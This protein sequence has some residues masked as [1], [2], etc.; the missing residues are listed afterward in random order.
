MSPFA[1][2]STPSAP[3]ADATADSAVAADLMR[4]LVV[5]DDPDTR[6]NLCDIL[7]LDGYGTETASTIAE[8]RSRKDVAAFD[9]IILDRKLPDGTA[10][11]LL[12]WL[13]QKGPDASVIVVTGFADLDGAIAALRAGAADYTLKP[14][15]ADALRARL[16]AIDEKRRLS[17]EKTRAESAFRTLIE[18]APCLIV[19]SRGPGEVVFVNSCAAGVTGYTQQ[20]LAE[21]LPPRCFL[22]GGGSPSENT[23]KRFESP[24]LCRDGVRHW[25]I[26]QTQELLDY[27]G[28]AALM[29][30]GQDITELQTAQQKAL[31][32]ERLAAIGQMMAGLSHESRNALQRSKACLEMLEFE[33][34]DRPEA[35]ELVQRLTKAQDHLQRLYEEVR[36]YAAPVQISREQ[37]N[38]VNVWREKWSHIAPLH[39]NKH[40]TLREQ[41]ETDH[42]FC[43]GDYFALGQV[44]GNILENAITVVPEPGEIVVACRE[45]KLGNEEALEVAFIDNGPGLD[46]EQAT[47]IF[48]PFFTTKTKGTGLGMAIAKRII[49]AHG[50]QISVRDRTAPGAEVVVVLP[51]GGD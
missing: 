4:V 12:P 18:A 38:V 22:V 39:P 35:M 11:E 29:A 13:K 19:I 3:V 37:C 1:R 8:V 31:Q 6:E 5:E 46:A 15:N 7:S 24:L 9:A 36:S 44:F 25:I 14:V 17:L 33:V 30:V 47:R 49:D 21:R 42:C 48:E 51:R 32:A 43:H 16:A 20:E 23:Q 2:T 27:K 10:D 26:W 34:A 41:I 40:V 28:A 45:V 50:G